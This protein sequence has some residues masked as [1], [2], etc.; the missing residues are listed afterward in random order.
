MFFDTFA[1]NAQL[2]FLI[3]V[4]IMALVVT[5]PLISSRSIPLVARI[6]LALFAAI[7]VFPMVQESGYPIPDTGLEYAALVVGEI[8]VGIILGFI[9]VIIYSAFLL[10]GQFFS[11]QMGFGASQ[12]FDP[13]AQIQ[14]PIM[15]QFLNIIAMFIFVLIGGFQ[16]IFLAGVLRS[17]EKVQVYDF[18]TQ[19]NYIFRLFLGSLGNLFEQ[20]LIISLPILGTLFLVSIS[21]GLLA[22]AA[23]QM[24]LL[25]LGFPVAIGVAFT[26]I[27]LSFPF[28]AE[29]FAK[30]IDASF[31]KIMELIDQTGGTAP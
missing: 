11:L 25:M 4:R 7:A 10:A 5:A 19:R 29:A 24:N 20:A 9:L 6:G 22:K 30:I 16:R 28:L 27:F 17:F 12:V 14:I 23:P 21:V 3:F 1:E 13:L 2:F 31:Y 26:I 18:I 8:M 15:G